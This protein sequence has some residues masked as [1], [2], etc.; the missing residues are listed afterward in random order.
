[1]DADIMIQEKERAG[2][3]VCEN[4]GLLFKELD[5]SGGGRL[6][7]GDFERVL[8]HN[9]VKLWFSALEVDIE[10]ANELFLLLCDEKGFVTRK[11]FIAGVKSLRGPTKNKDIFTLKQDMKKLHDAILQKQAFTDIMR[12]DA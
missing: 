10:E 12:R 3:A 2:K 4:L 5:E 9:K 8:L 6:D 7:K 11:D 1:M